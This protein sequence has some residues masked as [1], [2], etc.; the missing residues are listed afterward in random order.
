M[1]IVKSH[2]SNGAVV[3]QNSFRGQSS[4]FDVLTQ[5]QFLRSWKPVSLK[6]ALRVW[7]KTISSTAVLLLI[8]QR[9][10]YRDDI[11]RL[12]SNSTHTHTHIYVYVYIYD[13]AREPD[14]DQMSVGQMI[15]TSVWCT[16]TPIS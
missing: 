5:D 9:C 16:V 7:T 12:L 1:K 3:A 10:S 4:E 13:G 8:R 11:K 6:C 15:A 14:W 2:K